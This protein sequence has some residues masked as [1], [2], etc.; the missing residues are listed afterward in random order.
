MDRRQFLVSLGRAGLAGGLASIVGACAP[1]VPTLAPLATRRPAAFGTAPSEAPPS[2]STAPTA[3][4]AQRDSTIADENR[5]PGGRGWDL[6]S[7]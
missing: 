1:S 4:P 2:A 7:A 3:V 5:R 6:R